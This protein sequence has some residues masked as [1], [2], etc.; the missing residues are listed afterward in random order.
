MKEILRKVEEINAANKAGKRKL[1]LEYMK[2]ASFNRFMHFCLDDSLTFN[3]KRVELTTPIEGDFYD[4]LDVLNAQGSATKLQKEQ[5]AA[6]GSQSPEHLEVLNK[7]LRKNPDC[8]F[9]AKSMHAILPG[10]I[11]YWPYQRC[12]GFE[13]LDRIFATPVIDGGAWISDK[14]EDGMFVRVKTPQGSAPM[15]ETR[16]GKPL[17]FGGY[18][19]KIFLDMDPGI[20]DVDGVDYEIFESGT[21]FEGEGLVLNEAGTDFLPRKDGNAI[22][23][24]FLG[25]YGSREE[26]E[27]IRFSFWNV[28]PLSDYND[29]YSPLTLWR[30]RECVAQLI[31]YT[32]TR[33][34]KQ[35][36][37]RSVFSKEEAWDHYYEV[38]ARPVPEGY[39]QL[40]GTIC[41]HPD[42]IYQDGTSLLMAKCKSVREFEGEI[43]GWEPGKPGGKYE[44]KIGSFIIK[45][46]CGGLV[47]KCS[48]MTDSI[49]DMDPEE[50]VGQICTIKFNAVSNSKDRSKPR[51][52]DHSRFVEFRP[53]KNIADD[54][55]YI[56]K[57][58]SKKR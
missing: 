4:L 44:N 13:E 57:V 22:I 55:E 41:K 35:T 3:V 28:L 5:L 58:K 9:S 39:G 20:L 37:T 8:G 23:V 46:S 51:S 25:G 26:I 38:R 27:R 30:R 56:L 36:E 34:I 53:D 19:N 48:G 45:S 33:V 18:F 54:L 24:K 10:E 43:I 47:G 2:D 15:F 16:N 14:K 32:D 12:S 11:G 17:L 1:V 42:E 50:A 7:I 31:E 29:G 21:V 49:R 40:E 6:L 52:L